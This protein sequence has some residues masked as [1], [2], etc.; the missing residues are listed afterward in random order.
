MARNQIVWDMMHVVSYEHYWVVWVKNDIRIPRTD[1]P[2]SRCIP[3]RLTPNYS[4]Q[5]TSIDQ[6]AR[7]QDK[8]AK[9]KK[10]I[11]FPAEFEKKVRRSPPRPHRFHSFV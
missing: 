2:N 1:S 11:K 4:V 9:E 7:F 3:A 8:L 5:G 10:R 6:D